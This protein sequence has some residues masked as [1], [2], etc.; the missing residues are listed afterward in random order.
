MRATG[1]C[2]HRGAALVGYS[3]SI[4]FDISYLEAAVQADTLQGSCG[5]VV[6]PVRSVPAAL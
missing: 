5:T 6:L 1:T 4:R 3:W 2:R